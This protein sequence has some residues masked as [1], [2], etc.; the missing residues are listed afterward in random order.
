MYKTIVLVIVFCG[1]RLAGATYNDDG[2][3][4]K[5]YG[6][7]FEP[8]YIKKKVHMVKNNNIWDG[9]R[10]K[11]KYICSVV[12]TSGGYAVD[13]FLGKRLHIL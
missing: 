10:L 8:A 7:E 13:L 3:V 5:K 11:V 4:E 9:I 6:D 12:T 2:Y 1:S